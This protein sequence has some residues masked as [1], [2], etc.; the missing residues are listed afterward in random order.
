M[1][2]QIRITG[3]LCNWCAYAGADLAG[4][5]RIPF[6][7]TL[8]AVR[9]M[10]SGRVDPAFVIEA[11]LAGSDGVLIGGCHP[12]ECHYERGNHTAMT[13]VSLLKRLLAHMGVNPYR[14]RLEWI[15]SAEGIRFAQVIRDFTDVLENM[16]PLGMEMGTERS[17]L[18]LKLKAARNAVSGEKLR[19]VASRHERFVKEGNQYGEIFTQHELDR[20]LDGVVIEEL[21][22]HQILLM[23]SRGPMKKEEICCHLNA[24]ETK[25]DLWLDC[26]ARKEQIQLAGTRNGSPVYD[27]KRDL[28]EQG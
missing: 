27:L 12:G 28:L 20:M 5:S 3:F 11:F 25:I 21:L 16:G 9:V 22:I 23:L 4:V 14:L 2:A 15:S 24:P 8:R 13:T 26:L 18:R 7:P 1:D 10:C 19:W 6:P 17:N